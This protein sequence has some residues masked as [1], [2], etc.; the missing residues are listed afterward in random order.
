LQSFPNWSFEPGANTGLFYFETKPCGCPVRLEWSVRTKPGPKPDTYGHRRIAELLSDQPGWWADLKATCELLANPP[1][2]KPGPEVSL[3]WRKKYNIS[4]YADAFE[5]ISLGEIVQHIERRIYEGKRLNGTIRHR[6]TRPKRVEPQ[7]YGLRELKRIMRTALV[8]HSESIDR[9]AWR[10]IIRQELFVDWFAWEAPNIFGRS[11][12]LI[13]S[14]ARETLEASRS[15]GYVKAWKITPDLI[16]ECKQLLTMA[17][18]VPMKVRH[19]ERR[20]LVEQILDQL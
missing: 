4:S 19:P 20:S 3:H 10:E 17:A 11:I 13:E 9:D 8:D 1:D 12:D 15:P 7:S 2:G 6:A 5:R 14:V 18:T 16:E